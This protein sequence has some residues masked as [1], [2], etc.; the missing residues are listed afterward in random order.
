MTN[1]IQDV[2]G[3][4]HM[5]EKDIVTELLLTG[6]NVLMK[7]VSAIGETTSPLV[8]D[9]L[10]RHLNETID[11]HGQMTD[12][13]ISKGYYHPFNPSQQFKDDLKDAFLALDMEAWKSQD[14]E[15]GVKTWDIPKVRS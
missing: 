6:K 5:T 8:R 4:A 11:T 3:A 2:A 7:Y 12:Y 13:A 14:E 1:I 10:K 15:F 9:I